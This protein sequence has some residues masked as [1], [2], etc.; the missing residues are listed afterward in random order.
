MATLV[1]NESQKNAFAHILS[2]CKENRQATRLQIMFHTYLSDHQCKE[3]LYIMVK[4]GLLD[5]SN[6]TKVYGITHEGLR[7]LE[8]AR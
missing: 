8:A 4:N 7:L 6:E 3:Y 2:I 5:Y 1:K